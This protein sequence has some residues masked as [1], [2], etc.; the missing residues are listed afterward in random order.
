MHYPVCAAFSRLLSLSDMWLVDC[1][2][3]T[4]SMFFFSQGKNR[5]GKCFWKRPAGFHFAV[6]NSGQVAFSSPETTVS[7]KHDYDLLPS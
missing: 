2:Q 7:S 4:A 5:G 3:L 1:I 6:A